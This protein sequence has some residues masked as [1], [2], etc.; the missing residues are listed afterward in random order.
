MGIYVL[1]YSVMTDYQ[2][3]TTPA[4]KRLWSLASKAVSIRLAPFIVGVEVRTHF[5]LW[6]VADLFRAKEIGSPS[7]PALAG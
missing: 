7:V 1:H 2:L 4:Q 5:R 6:N 3:Y